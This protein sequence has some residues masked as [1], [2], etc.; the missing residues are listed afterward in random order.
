[1]LTGAGAALLAGAAA[2][3]AAHALPAMPTGTDGPD[4]GL[5]R[6]H[7]ALVAQGA[8]IARLSAEQEA[9]PYPYG[10]PE[11]TAQEARMTAAE[12]EWETIAEQITDLP[13]QGAAGLRAKAAALLL[14]LKHDVCHGLADSL[15]DI[16][17]GNVGDPDHRLSLSLARD[18]LREGTPA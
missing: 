3:T 16:A 8:E 14:V 10:T 5:I 7:A 18:L 12:C 13:A 17:V 15:D 2:V 1:M 9:S 4:A 6:L 11:S